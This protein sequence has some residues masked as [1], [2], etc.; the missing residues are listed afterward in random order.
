MQNREELSQKG[1]NRSQKT[2]Y[3]K[4]EKKFI[5][6]RGWGGINFLFGP[7]YRPLFLMASLFGLRGACIWISI[8]ILN[9]S[10]SAQNECDPTNKYR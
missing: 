4:R 5:L 2:T 3:R 8:Q 1:H 7:K 6:E 9:G 10:G